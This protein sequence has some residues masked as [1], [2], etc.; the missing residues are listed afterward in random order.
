MKAWLGE[1]PVSPVKKLWDPGG[2]G[3]GVCGVDDDLLQGM[4][5]AED[6]KED[7]VNV[8]EE[9]KRFGKEDDERKENIRKMLDPRR[10]AKQEVEDHELF[11]LPYRN[12]CPDCVR[13]KGKELDHR[14]SLE[15]PRGLSEYS[16]DYCFPGDEFGY[17]LTILSGKEKVTGMNFA[18]AVPTKG[19]SG[20]FASDKT[21]EFM[22]EVGDKATKVIIKSDQEPSITYLVN[23]VVATRP[24]GQTCIE[25]SP[26][27]SSGSN[28]RV[29]RG[30]QGLE[31]QVRVMLL[32]L[33]G[34]LGK[35]L[36]AR[37]PIVNFMPEYAAYLLNRKEVGQD[38]KTSYER[39]KGKKATVLGIEFGEKLLYK[40]KPKDKQEKINSRWEY[41]I[42][43]GVRRRSGELW[44]AVK[45]SVFAVRSVR[46]IPVEERWNEDCIK[47][48]NRA[49]WNRYKGDEYADGEV[50][51]Q[52]TA[53]SDPATAVN[54]GGGTVIIETRHRMPREFYIKKS[55]A[56]KFGYTR[57]CGGCNS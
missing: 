42:F 38:G 51:E 52:V 11:H 21:V 10:P 56:D 25:E 5:L 44:V 32:A 28:G 27:K 48:V 26:V 50:P 45:D 39:C 20:K 16:F 2:V 40:V 6:E 12:W 34:R 46:R 3:C 1:E 36:S 4:E 18:T 49:P 22:E 14:K 7:G 15:E 47:W 41:A 24:E 29:E 55:D 43:I 9:V 53:Q 17:K 54:T 30:I 35:S 57:N 8:G 13:A 33:E 19:A 23:D 37:E 31:G